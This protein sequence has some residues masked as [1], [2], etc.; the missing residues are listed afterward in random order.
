M[1]LLLKQEL[2]GLDWTKKYE[3]VEYYVLYSENI[4]CTY[5]MAMAKLRKPFSL[6]YGAKN[7]GPVGT[8][9]RH[10]LVPGH[11]FTDFS[12]I[13]AYDMILACRTHDLTFSSPVHSSLESSPVI[14]D[15]LVITM[16]EHSSHVIN[17][18]C[19]R[20]LVYYSND[21]LNTISQADLTTGD[22]VLEIANT[23]IDGVG[24]SP[25]HSDHSL[26]HAVAMPKREHWCTEDERALTYSLSSKVANLQKYNNYTEF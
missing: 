18:S 24:K 11:P 3:I 10:E 26:A 19:S 21:D 8:W 25:A 12:Y 5:A 1:G 6:D 23:G 7:Y 16:L 13:A 9:W 20:N 22:N 14:I 15:G 4:A 2:H 17:F